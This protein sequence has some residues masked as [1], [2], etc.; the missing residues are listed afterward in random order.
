MAE[1]TKAPSPLRLALRASQLN[2][3]H[4]GGLNPG[5]QR[6]VRHDVRQIEA[7]GTY[8]NVDLEEVG[9][10]T[11][12]SFDRTTDGASI[13]MHLP[14]LYPFSPP[15]VYINH[16]KAALD[17]RGPGDR[18]VSVLERN[19]SSESADKVLVLCHCTRVEGDFE[20]VS[21][22]WLG[23]LRA[24]ECGESVYRMV[25]RTFGVR[26]PTGRVTF[27]TVDNSPSERNHATFVEDAFSSAF[28]DDHPCEYDAILVPDCGGVW[29]LT[30]YE[31]STV[32]Q[33]EQLLA[34][35]V[36]M[37]RMLKP[38]G[39]I[40]FSKLSGDFQAALKGRLE[41][42]GCTVSG[43]LFYGVGRCIVARVAA[44]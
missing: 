29:Y 7:T 34:A 35:C 42:V 11:R 3:M 37:L 27:H 40:F 14:D 16:R 12:L 36:G 2:R 32:A 9:D 8:R 10:G 1:T 43:A 22:H 44:A 23:E 4:R 5:H 39:L 30:I 20:N 24:E 41:R 21:G 13:R 28:A 26:I 38:N 25:M 33:K 6:R 17:W 19:A 18:I 15:V 31:E